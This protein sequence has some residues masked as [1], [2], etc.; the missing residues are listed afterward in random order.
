MWNLSFFFIFLLYFDNLFSLKRFISVKTTF[1]AFRWSPF[2]RIIRAMLFISPNIILSAW[3][4]LTIT[5]ISTFLNFFFKVINFRLR[6]RMSSLCLIERLFYNINRW[7]L[8]NFLIISFLL[9]SLK[10]TK[11]TCSCNSLNNWI[12]II[13]N[14][15]SIKHFF[16]FIQGLNYFLFSFLS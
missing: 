8:W 10:R 15:N 16:S 13:G 9:I 5:F 6:L 11:G 1:Y 12:N 3:W 4:R 7:C 14:S 2:S